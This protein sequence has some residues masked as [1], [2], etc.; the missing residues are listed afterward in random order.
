MP[1]LP[2]TCFANLCTVLQNPFDK[3]IQKDIK[4]SK[5]YKSYIKG[6]LSNNWTLAEGFFLFKNRIWVR[7]ANIR[8]EIIKTFYNSLLGGHNGS[9]KIIHHIRS[10]YN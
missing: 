7:D 10:C 5:K 1:I 9:R 4:N 3:E 2:E 8:K 6:E